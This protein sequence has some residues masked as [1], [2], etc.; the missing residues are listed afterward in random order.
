[1]VLLM[2]EIL[3]TTWDVW[4]PIK[5][6]INEIN[7]LSTGAG[8]LPPTVPKHQCFDNPHK[9]LLNGND[10]ELIIVTVNRSDFLS[11]KRCHIVDLF[12]CSMCPFQNPDGCV[13]VGSYSMSISWSIW[14]NLMM[15]YEPLRASLGFTLRYY[16]DQLYHW[17]FRNPTNH[18]KHA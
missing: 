4:N 11:Q 14:L 12:A 5:I 13:A 15:I 6:Y 2:A 1:V 10:W 17:R 3:L 16:P 9:I 7:Y 18:W 8:F